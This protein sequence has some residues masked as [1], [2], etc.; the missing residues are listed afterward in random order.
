[1]SSV[2]G[3]LDIEL[4]LEVPVVFFEF[5]NLVFE[6]FHLDPEIFFNLLNLRWELL[7][8]FLRQSGWFS[9]SLLQIQLRNFLSKG[10]NLIIQA[11][12]FLFF[13][14]NFYLSCV[15]SCFQL[16]YLKKEL[17]FLGLIF[18]FQRFDFWA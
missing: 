10:V 9:T 4:G 7:D 8:I 5:V 11:P 6:A 3:L 14:V 12:I 18:L 1:M 13:L 2:C 15:G 16:F 17:I